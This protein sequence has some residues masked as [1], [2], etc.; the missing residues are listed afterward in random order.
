[1]SAEA[2]GAAGEGAGTLRAEIAR[3]R[4]DLEA[5]RARGFLRRFFGLRPRTSDDPE[6]TREKMRGRLAIALVVTLM[7]VVGLTFWYL[8][9]LS[10]KFGALTTDDLIALIPMV[11]TTL[12]TPL[13]GLI[14]AVM[15]FYYG[16]QTAVQ[17]ASQATETAAQAASQA[18]EAATKGVETP[19]QA[20]TE[21]AAQVATER[22]TQ[23][24]TEKATQVATERA[25]QVATER[26]TQVATQVVTQ[27]ATEEPPEE[28]PEG[29]EPIVFTEP[30]GLRFLRSW[31]AR[32]RLKRTMIRGG[33]PLR[34][35][36]CDGAAIT[37]RGCA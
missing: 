17:A 33:A 11:G 21:R 16:G 5:E 4:A 2:N 28:Q 8:L 35:L 25:A 18:T 13:V 24:A 22:A 6:R 3:L 32:S 30:R 31:V 29:R 14:G 36:R 7:V 20:A 10:R 19:T 37:R 26:A 15:G 23:V 12:L 1:M 9:L 27:A 34:P